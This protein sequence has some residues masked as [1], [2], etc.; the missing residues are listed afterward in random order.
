MALLF[1]VQQTL[2]SHVEKNLVIPAQRLKQIPAFKL[3]VPPN[4]S[5]QVSK[6]GF[7]ERI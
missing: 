1:W 6:N 4:T 5:L 3:A 7:W 2:P